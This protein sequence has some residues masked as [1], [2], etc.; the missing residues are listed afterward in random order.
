MCSMQNST[1]R[2]CVLCNTIKNAHVF[3]INNRMT[4]KYSL[5]HPKYSIFKTDVAPLHGIAAAA[6]RRSR[7]AW[8]RCHRSRTHSLF[9]WPE[10][11]IICLCHSLL[12]RPL[13]A[14]VRKFERTTAKSMLKWS[15][16]LTP[17]VCSWCR[18]EHQNYIFCMPWWKKR[19]SCHWSNL[20][21][22]IS[23]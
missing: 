22:S 15:N 1:E 13:H 4:Q 10:S 21:S 16:L 19:C 6:R 7:A 8:K 20:H 18:Q 3:Y 11:G 2:A 5:L 17:A 9:H 14:A 23:W 12:A